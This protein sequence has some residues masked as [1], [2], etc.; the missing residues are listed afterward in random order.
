MRSRALDIR[1][2]AVFVGVSYILAWLVALPLWLGAGM[3]DP[4]FGVYALAM[5]ATPAIGALVATRWAEKPSERP[6]GPGIA[7]SLG[8][9]PLKPVGRLLLFLLAGLLLPPLL[10]LGGLLLGALFGV[11]PA[12]FAHLTM[13]RQLLASQVPGAAEQ[14]RAIPAPVLIAGQLAAVL[15]GSIINTIPALGEEIGWRGW[16][17]PRLR[18]LGTVGMVLV[19]GV[20]WGLWHAPLILLGYNYPGVP[21][22]LGLAA[23][24]AMTISFGAVLAWLR[25]ASD[26][27]W[28]AALAHGAF[29][30]SAGLSL[31]FALPVPLNMLWVAPLG[32]SGWIL[33]LLLAVLLFRGL[34]A[35]RGGTRDAV[36]PGPA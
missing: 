30:A 27:V 10:V 20:I 18:P 11:Y 32:F 35:G 24:C 8:L 4:L 16:L 19:S 6:G 7:R 31:V 21:G 14:I 26:S 17:V 28:P 34:R 29:N 13:F 36:P 25:L 2:L 15:L 33:P 22:W 5:M 9:W 12:D 23:M 1:A 3:R